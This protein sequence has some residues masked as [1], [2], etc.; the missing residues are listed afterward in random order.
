M[1][2]RSLVAIVALAA[3]RP[4]P[5]QQASP[6]QQP[7]QQPP[8]EQPRPAAPSTAGSQGQSSTTQPSSPGASSQQVVVNPPPEK[9]PSTQQPPS[10][11]VV[12]P[13]PARDADVVVERRP[14]RNPMATVAIDAAYGGVAGLLV[15]T[16]VALVDEWDDWQRSLM[17]GAGVGLLVGAGVGAV[18]AAVEARDARAR[19]RVARD[20][21]NRTDRD[22]V[23]AV[24][25]RVALAFRF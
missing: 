3:A 10:T 2:V 14:E 19:H 23:I 24:P 5:G 16:G 22:P 17:V 15:G 4:A 7:E 6:P 12:N 8:S 9:Q 13:P 25:P 21:M 11:T 20:G 18:H 1:V